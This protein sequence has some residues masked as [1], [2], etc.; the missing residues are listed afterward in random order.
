MNYKIY[1]FS[2]NVNLREI[3]LTIEILISVVIFSM[4]SEVDVMFTFFFENLVI[5]SFFCV[6]KYL[7][8]KYLKR[9]FFLWYFPKTKKYLFV[10]QCYK[11][12]I[13]IVYVHLL[14]LFVIN[15]HVFGNL[16]NYTCLCIPYCY[17]TIDLNHY[18][19]FF[20]PRTILQ[21]QLLLTVT[22]KLKKKNTNNSNNNLNR[23]AD[24]YNSIWRRIPNS[25]TC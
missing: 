20:W 7:F 3:W 6:K 12:K 1:G 17:F 14:Q 2:Y 19:F 16:C 23:A 4:T 21:R 18:C 25:V 22:F 24:W 9:I 8:Q 13:I 11:L 10:H 15:K 5:K